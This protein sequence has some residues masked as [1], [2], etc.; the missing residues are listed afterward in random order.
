MMNVL[1]STCKLLTKE[2]LNILLNP[3]ESVIVHL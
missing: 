2:T 3:D 1:L